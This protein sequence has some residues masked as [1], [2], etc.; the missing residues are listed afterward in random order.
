[1]IFAL[2]PPAA[3]RIPNILAPAFP[4]S[5][6]IRNAQAFAP[7]KGDSSFTLFSSKDYIKQPDVSRG[8][9]LLSQET[10]AY[11]YLKEP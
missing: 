3:K 9:I 10:D 5:V 7:W 8:I 1:M 6:P 4:A 11:Y 2:A